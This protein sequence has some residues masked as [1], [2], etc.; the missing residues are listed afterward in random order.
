MMSHQIWKTARLAFLLLVLFDFSIVVVE[1]EETCSANV[2]HNDTCTS[3]CN[4]SRP[5]PK[6]SNWA[7]RGECFKNP[8]YME[9]ECAKSCEICSPQTGADM[10]IPQVMS[11][12][13]HGTTEAQVVER[14]QEARAYL[15]SKQVE[16]DIKG[17]CRN[18]QDMCGVWAVTG[19]CTEDPEYMKENCAPVCFGC[20]YYLTGN[21]IGVAQILS[22]EKHH[23]TTSTV[24]ERLQEARAY[25][26]SKKV[27]PELKEI[28]RNK[29]DMCGVWA[30]SGECT[31]N[32]D[33]MKDKCAPSCFSCD[34]LTVEGRCP[35]DPNTPK[36][37]EPGD[38][39]KMF[40]RLTSEPYKTQHEVQILSRD[41]WVITMENVV[42]PEEAD[43][44]IEL[45]GLEGYKTSTA[46]GKRKVDG[47]R[48][49]RKTENR[50]STNAWCMK[51]CYQDET[52]LKVVYRMSN[53]TQIEERN[54][55][56]VQLLRYTEG[57][58]YKSHHDYLP[59]HRQRQ[60]GV[61]ILTMYLYLNDVEA[62]G[63]TNFDKLNIT[64]MPKRGRALLWPSVLDEKPNER[65]DR[66]THQAMPVEKG[67]K[68]G[69]NAWFHMHDF[70]TPFHN[71]CR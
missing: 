13:P 2:Q 32:A 69:A 55:E 18:K 47:K 56:Y 65:D 62:G 41:P 36:A 43:Q 19:R 27:K 7:Q 12:G 23:A 51:E 16:P 14:F 8:V 21:D 4:D 35:I 49:K 59:H 40:E 39:N 57:Q 31:K 17:I 54:S 11:S 28:C 9:R 25:L 60:S 61:R 30:V 1:A 24:V 44:L 10:G 34:Y 5:A 45:G 22:S 26:N 70:K 68:F 46:V 37:W 67:L 20:D 52:A 48:E 58:F 29:K 33:F 63:G 6:C 66:T 38:L 64:V 15:K 53:L 42:L 3:T 50:T 71:G